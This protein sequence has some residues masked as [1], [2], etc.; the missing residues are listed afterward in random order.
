M[1]ILILAI[2]LTFG[3]QLYLG[4]AA[5]IMI[6][7]SEKSPKKPLIKKEYILF[8][9][10]FILVPPVFIGERSAT[11]LGI[12]YSIDTL[13]MNQVMALRSILILLSIRM[14]TAGISMK[15]VTEWIECS[16]FGNLG[17]IMKISHMILPSIQQILK[18]SVSEM[19]SRWKKKKRIT[20]LFDF[21]VNL[22]VNI[23]SF[24]EQTDSPGKKK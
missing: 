9:F 16:G 10:I 19:K 24:A 20:I 7:L 13:K 3:N 23:I 17:H 18:D 4:T 12:R 14:F 5:G 6:L 2:L 1:S 8:L 22:S 15:K 21:A 11:A